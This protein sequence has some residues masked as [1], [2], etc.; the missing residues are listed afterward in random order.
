M[1]YPII[2]D[3]PF[4][5]IGMTETQADQSWQRALVGRRPIS[6]VARAIEKE[7]THGFIKLLV[8]AHTKR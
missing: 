4:G 7:D 6:T 5:R 1:A 3:P 2:I 8:A